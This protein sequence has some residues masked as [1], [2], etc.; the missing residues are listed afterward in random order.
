MEKL[1]I[2][3]SL[4]RNPEMV[5]N[6]MDGEIV[7]MS[8]ENSE[9]YGLDPVASRI[10]ELL[11]FPATIDELIGKLL[12]EYEVSRETCEKDVLAF[13]EELLEKNII[14]TLT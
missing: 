5:Y 1:S 4:R 8:I 7:M 3:T 9:Y 14:T 12:L 13:S 6:E 2:H 10:W 11:E